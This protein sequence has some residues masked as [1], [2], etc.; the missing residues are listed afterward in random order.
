MNLISVSVVDAAD[1]AEVREQ[2]RSILV[3]TARDPDLRAVSRDTPMNS[4]GFYFRTNVVRA[5]VETSKG[6]PLDG[7]FEITISAIQ[8][9]AS[10]RELEIDVASTL[11]NPGMF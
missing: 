6:E 7:L 8:R 4:K 5:D 11:A 1:E 3:Q 9:R 2:L 10:G